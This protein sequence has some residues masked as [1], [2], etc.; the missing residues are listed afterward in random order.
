[1][2]NAI[3][4]DHSDPDFQLLKNF[5]DAWRTDLALI[6]QITLQEMQE[7]EDRILAARLAGITLDAI[8][9]EVRSMAMLLHD[10]DNEN[11]HEDEQT[12]MFSL[13]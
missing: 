5:D 10:S 4:I 1:M 11:D 3:A 8:P 9:D 2:A 12:S 6:R 7:E 13:L